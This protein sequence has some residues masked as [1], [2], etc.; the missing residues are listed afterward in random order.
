M[1]PA[2]SVAAGL[3]RSPQIKCDERSVHQHPALAQQILFRNVGIDK[4]PGDSVKAGALL[5][6][7]HFL[8]GFVEFFV[9]PLVS[10]LFPA[11]PPQLRPR[12]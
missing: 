9:S 1:W 8:V 12:A 6:A 11:H 7:S 4:F 3:L 5:R 2:R 10:R